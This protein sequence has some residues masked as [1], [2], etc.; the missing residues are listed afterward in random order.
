MADAVSLSDA[1]VLTDAS[2]HHFD[3]SQSPVISDVM[4][5]GGFATLI[6]AMVANAAAAAVAAHSDVADVEAVRSAVLNAINPG[7]VE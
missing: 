1:L 4:P 3:N 2:T 7:V 6:A 5:P